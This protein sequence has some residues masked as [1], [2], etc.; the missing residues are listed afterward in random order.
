MKVHHL[1]VFMHEHIVIKKKMAEH[2]IQ[3]GGVDFVFVFA[4]N[5]FLSSRNLRDCLYL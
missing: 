1:R 3:L 5:F 4:F 2:P